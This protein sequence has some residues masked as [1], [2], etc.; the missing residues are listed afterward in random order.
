MI[1]F[2]AQRYNNYLNCTNKYEYI[3]QLLTHFNLIC[4]LHIS[5]LLYHANSTFF[6]YVINFAINYTTQKEKRIENNPNAPKFKLEI[7]ML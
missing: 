5:N 2:L 6:K 7:T 1:L 4:G 3:L